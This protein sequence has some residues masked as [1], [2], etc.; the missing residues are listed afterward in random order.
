MDAVVQD[1]YGD[2]GVLRLERIPRPEVGA[3]DVLVRVHAAGVS[4]GVWHQMTGLPYPIRIAG[5]GLRAPNNRVRG[6]DLAGRVEGVGADVTAFRPGDEVYGFGQGTFADFSLARP[7]K[8]AR[9]PANLTAEQAA[10][11]PDSGVTALQA[12]RKGGVRAGHK[13]LV[14]GASGGVGTFAV[15][16]AKAAGGEVTGVASTGK[17]DLVRSLGADHV[18]DYTRD[19]LSGRDHTYDVILDIAGNRSL[20]S[21]RRLLTPE[22]TLVITGGE[23]GGRWLGG[24]DRQ[25]RAMAMSPFVKHRLGTFIASENAGDLGALT[26]LIE[27]GQVIP[28]L[29]RTYPLADA[30]AAV[31]D[32]RAGRI[33]GKAV[34]VTAP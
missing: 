17:L 1:A 30:P 9:R 2:A 15:Q 11:T 5:Y 26:E 14:L 25:V 22:G 6:G 27:A 34:V 12:V 18:V 24:T 20:T 13:V 32:L 16:I 29:D 28:A 8:L 3:D 33:R 21:L 19:D 7:D 4:Q 23:G 31:R 10:A